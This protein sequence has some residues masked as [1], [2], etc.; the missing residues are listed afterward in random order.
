MTKVPRNAADLNG[1]FQDVSELSPETT[2]AVVDAM[3]REHFG[4]E[5]MIVEDQPARFKIGNAN[6]EARLLARGWQKGPDG[7]FDPDLGK[8]KGGVQS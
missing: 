3:L 5:V 7:L 2:L 1:H 8:R 4:L 6:L